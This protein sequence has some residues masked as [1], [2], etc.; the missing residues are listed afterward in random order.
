MMSTPSIQSLAVGTM[1]NMVY[2][3]T[4]PV[5]G[6]RVLIDPANEFEAILDALGSPKLEWILLTH[7]DKDHFLALDALRQ[8]SGA[9]VAMHAADL[10]MLGGRAV[11]RELHDGDSVVFGEARLRVLHTPGHTPG[12]LCFYTPPSLISGD[13]LFPGGPGMTDRPLG[14]F[15][16][17]I[18]SIQRKLFTLPDETAVYPGHGRGTT[19]AAEQPHLQEW[20]DRGW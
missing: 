17:I 13:T 11:D 20:I 15:A 9:L 19:I 14:D 18:D 12:S 3:L 5:T 6:A 8:A 16:L 7:G 4:C 10:P 2:I 1:G